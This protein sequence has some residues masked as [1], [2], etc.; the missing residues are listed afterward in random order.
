MDPSV[1]G[2]EVKS[3]LHPG[4]TAYLRYFF[5]D[6]EKSQMSTKFAETLQTFDEIGKLTIVTNAVLEKL[7]NQDTINFHNFCGYEMSTHYLFTSGTRNCCLFIISGTDAKNYKLHS[8]MTF[9]FEPKNLFIDAFCANQINKSQI[10]NPGGKK[11]LDIVNKACKKLKIKRILLDS[12]HG[13]LD[14]YKQKGF[15][16]DKER[17][18]FGLTSL[19]KKI[20][21]SSRSSSSTN[22]K[23]NQTKKTKLQKHLT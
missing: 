17:Y 10:D 3:T 20:S 4:K 9:K 14:W 12:V 1:G 5:I 19:R 11:L 6:N 18:A 16:N 15:K 8:V 13:A 23:S 2:I 22:T 21:W 7:K